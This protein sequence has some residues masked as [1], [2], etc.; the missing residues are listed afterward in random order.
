MGV[1]TLLAIQAVVFA[2]AWAFVKFRASVRP[3]GFRL[4]GVRLEMFRQ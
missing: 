1:V 2:L 4:L 3:I